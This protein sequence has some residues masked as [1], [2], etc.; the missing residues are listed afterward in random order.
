MARA[1]GFSDD[2]R[3]VTAAATSPSP[4]TEA[5]N[6]SQFRAA[7]VSSTI[8]GLCGIGAV[9]LTIFLTKG[10]NDS[11]STPALKLGPISSPES[12]AHVTNPITISGP[13]SGLKAGQM[14]W[15]FNQPDG[16]GPYFPNSGPCPVSNGVWTCKGIWIGPSGDAGKGSYKLAAVVVS[17]QEAFD[18]VEHLRCRTPPSCTETYTTMPGLDLSPAQTVDV[19]R[20]K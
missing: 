18:I 6:K 19:T 7:L 16:A 12:L 20:V 9:I 4:D 14:V 11:P 10:S 13:A 1:A 15:T 17:E 2:A 3:M 5:Q 8:T